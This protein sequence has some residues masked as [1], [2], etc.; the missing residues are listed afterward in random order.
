MTVKVMAY[1]ALAYSHWAHFYNTHINAKTAPTNKT[2]YSS[3]TK[4]IE[5]VLTNHVEFIS[6]HITPLVINSLRGRHTHTN[7][8]TD[9]PDKSNFK[10]PSTSSQGPDAWFKSIHAEWFTVT[11]CCVVQA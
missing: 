11:L 3:H 9:F 4:A 6:C 2:N 5:F 8:R 1:T 7:T 10:K